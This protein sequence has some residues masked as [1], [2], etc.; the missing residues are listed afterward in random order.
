[1]EA[2]E[3]LIDNHFEHILMGNHIEIFE[4]KSKK[5]SFEE[6]INQKFEAYPKQSINLGFTNSYYWLRFRLKNA[7][8]TKTKVFLEI[9][10]PHINKLQL[11]TVN[12]S[13]ISKSILTGDHFPFPQRA[14]N[15]A[16]FVFPI[17]LNPQQSTEF[18]LWVD[19]H[20]EQLAIPLELWGEKDFIDYSEKLS[21][22]VG[23]TLGIT[24]VWVI[25]SLFMFLFFRQFI[26]F[27]YWIYTSA[28][29]IFLV[30][31]SGFGFKY[32]WQ[33]ATWWTSSARPIS[34]MILYTCSVLFARQFFEIRKK[35][36][37][38]NI[39]TILLTFVLPTLLVVILYK[40][41]FLGLVKNYW[42]NPNY[43]EGSDL[44]IFMKILNLTV[45]VVLWSIIGIGIYDYIKTRKTESLWFTFGFSMLLLSG[46]LTV[47]IFAGLVP[48]NYLT[49]NFPLI[50]N[51]LEIIILS[52]LL[53]NRYKN[54]YADNAKISAQLAEQRQQNAIQLLEGQM[55]ERRRLSQELHDG[56]SLTLANIRLRL[57][58]LA[59][60]FSSKEMDNLVENLGE[61]GQDVRQFSHALSPVLLEKHG[62][63]DAIEELTQTIQSNQIRLEIK[64]KH[65][66][67]DE[68][69]LNNLLKQTIYQIILELLNNTIRHANATE[70]QVWLH[71]DKNHL[72]LEVSDNGVGYEV[73]H[74]K[75]G[76]GLQNIKART[77]SLYGKF[78]IK[79]QGIGMRHLVEIPIKM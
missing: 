50:A 11:F 55:I 27:Y 65:D 37:F 26:T 59:E 63:I 24:S 73:L 21:L 79:R 42:Y 9:S 75:S 53:A 70:L 16:H 64:F 58:M 76:I 15:H 20:G 60:K 3:V 57:S 43:Y 30:A 13:E 19:K 67:I 35:N 40:S 7:D 41:P 32:I 10:N 46:T 52:F 34:S 28:C 54:I 22:F 36:R 8:S 48:D 39:F 18:Y 44:L 4:D 5:K 56:I 17:E 31:H 66:H 68:K 12:G 51:P 74:K 14:Y 61:V 1:M 45:I 77:Q 72:F 23:L 71:Q 29:W 49:Q 25:I 33:N 62:L 69:S 2:Q 38:I 47:F 78:Q 6:A